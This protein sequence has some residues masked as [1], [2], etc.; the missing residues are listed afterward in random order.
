MSNHDNL[1]SDR[2]KKSL[3]QIRD[4]DARAAGAAKRG[5]F[6]LIELLVVIAI[7]AI[8]ASLLLPALA[9]AKEKG[10]AIKCLSNEKQI[11]LGYLLYANLSSEPIRLGLGVKIGQKL[12][13]KVLKPLWAKCYDRAAPAIEIVDVNRPAVGIAVLPDHHIA[14]AQVGEVVGEGADGAQDG[15]GVPARLVFDAL[16]LDRTLAQ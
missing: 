4:P 8:L 9:R 15:I 16:A 2:E 6:T 12:P 10:K 13:N 5:A 7:I 11:G 3:G 14:A 1:Q